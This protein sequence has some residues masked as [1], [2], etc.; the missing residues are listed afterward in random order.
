MGLMI[1]ERLMINWQMKLL[2]GKFG[3]DYIGKNYRRLTPYIE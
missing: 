1:L 3:L 2:I